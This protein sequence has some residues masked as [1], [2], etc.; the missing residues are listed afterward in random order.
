MIGVAIEE[1]YIGSVKQPIADYIPEFEGTQF[2]DITIENLLMMRSNI[3]Y[4]EGLVWF[5]DDAKTLSQLAG[6]VGDLY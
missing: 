4:I 2:E 1:G 6:I 5:T 3:S